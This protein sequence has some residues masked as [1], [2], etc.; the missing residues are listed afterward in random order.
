MAFD[1]ENLSIITNNVKAGVV[2]SKWMFWNES[3]DTVTAAGYFTDNRLAVGDQ[4]EVV[5]AAYTS[6][7]HYYV[8]AVSSGA[9]TAVILSAS[10]P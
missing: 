1:R 2:P 5:V 10:T 4:I 8:S 3:S 9:A 6:V 7:L